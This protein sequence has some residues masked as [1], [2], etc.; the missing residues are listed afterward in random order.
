M[1]NYKKLY[2]YMFNHYTDLIEDMKKI[3]Q[4]AEEMYLETLEL[5][6]PSADVTDR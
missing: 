4:Q 1:E 2:F 3:Q 6:D 5:E